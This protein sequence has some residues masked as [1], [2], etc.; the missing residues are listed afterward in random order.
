MKKNLS[1]FASGFIFGLGLII[2]QMINPLKV[3]GF[4]DVAGQWDPSLAL[5]MVGALSSFS[6]LRLIINQNLKKTSS[7][8]PKADLI[9]KV[10]IDTQL[11]TGSAIFGIG[12]GLSGLCPGPAI[13]NITSGQLG[14]YV[15]VATLFIGF[16]VFKTLHGD[17]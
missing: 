7:P 3:L 8:H 4:L 15:F 1:A 14:T 16:F 12:W 10:K 17:K 2:G 5:V 11:I 13:V 6:V 9:T